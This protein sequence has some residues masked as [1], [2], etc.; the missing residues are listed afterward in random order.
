M[1]TGA[2]QFHVNCF[3]LNLDS[4]NIQ[5]TFIYYWP[6]QHDK[7]RSREMIHM[8]ATFNFDISL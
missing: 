6:C 5:Y 2:T 8:S 1:Q 3:L 7:T 4:V